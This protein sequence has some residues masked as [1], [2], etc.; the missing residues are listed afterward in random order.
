MNEFLQSQQYVPP[1]QHRVGRWLDLLG[2]RSAGVESSVGAMV[3]CL[4]QFNMPVVCVSQTTVVHSRKR[5]NN[6]LHPFLTLVTRGLWLPI[7]IVQV[8]RHR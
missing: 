7:W 6:L 2:R 3:S 8:I 5:V 1:E 4:A